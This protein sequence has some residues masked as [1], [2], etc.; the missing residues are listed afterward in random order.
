[1]HFLLDIT[2]SDASVS[3]SHQVRK[4]KERT[5]L[6]DRFNRVMEKHR[7]RIHVRGIDG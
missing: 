2:C 1:M 5:A 6:E 3:C 7:E 4:Q